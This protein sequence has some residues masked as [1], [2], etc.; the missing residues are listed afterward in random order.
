MKKGEFIPL[1]L[2]VIS[3]WNVPKMRI[4][5]SPRPSVHPSAYYLFLV[6]LT[7]ITVMAIRDRENMGHVSQRGTKPKNDR[8]DKGQKQFTSQTADISSTASKG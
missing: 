7:I 3:L 6:H 1:F 2:W 4:L 5:A 8:A